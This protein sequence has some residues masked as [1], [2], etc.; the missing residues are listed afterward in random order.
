MKVL[1]I[2]FKACA[3][4]TEK[5]GLVKTLKDFLPEDTDVTVDELAPE[6]EGGIFTHMLYKI[7]ARV[8][9][10]KDIEEL[11]DRILG[12]LSEKDKCVLSD[13]I[14]ERVD[15]DC[16]FY[17]RLSK[18]KLAAGEVVLQ[19]KDS[20]HVKFKIASYPARRENAVKAV[21]DLLGR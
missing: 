21:E 7:Q 12:G 6:T 17:V 19:S 14:E 11:V 10:K 1:N 2:R 16:N 9:R 8:L 15:E 4:E 13:N 18:E 3:K 5:D 20:V